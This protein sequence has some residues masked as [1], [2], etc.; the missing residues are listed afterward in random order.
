ML[1]ISLNIASN[2]MIVSD[3]E[4]TEKWKEKIEE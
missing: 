4:L 3:G 2:N 1:S